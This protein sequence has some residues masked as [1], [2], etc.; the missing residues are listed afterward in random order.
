MSSLGTWL[1]VGQGSTFTMSTRSRHTVYVVTHLDTL[2]YPTG[3]SDVTGPMGSLLG[4]RD[5]IGLDE[6]SLGHRTSLRGP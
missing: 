1:S 6:G 3:S 4:L 2:W 5:R